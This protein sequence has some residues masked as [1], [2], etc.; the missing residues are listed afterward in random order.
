M[1]TAHR[2]HFF[3]FPNPNRERKGLEVGEEEVGASILV[4]SALLFTKHSRIK[5][6]MS[7]PVILSGLCSVLKFF[8]GSHIKTK[9]IIYTHTYSHGQY[10]VIN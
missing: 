9:I 2:S 3:S 8:Q 7:P 1:V 4:I 6:Q 5:I 10:E